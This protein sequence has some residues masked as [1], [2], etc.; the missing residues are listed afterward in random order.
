MARVEICGW[1]PFLDT[2]GHDAS[3]TDKFEDEL[4]QT[5]NAHDAAVVSHTEGGSDGV[6]K[7]G[8][9]SKKQMR[10][11]EGAACGL[12]LPHYDSATQRLPHILKDDKV[13]LPYTMLG[14]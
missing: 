5:D 8:L 2:G 12:Q 11:E 10:A 13:R 14:Q 6:Y 3:T 1:L 7:T 4:I 9:L